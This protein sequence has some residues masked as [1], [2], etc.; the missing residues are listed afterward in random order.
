M[1]EVNEDASLL[2]ATSWQALGRAEIGRGDTRLCDSTVVI[3]FA[4]FFLE[5]SLTE[6][7]D[8]LGRMQDMRDFLRVQHPGLQDKLGW[9]YNEY[10]ARD[11]APT[12]K[13]MYK[14]GITRKLRRRFP[15]FS[16]I[17]KF[18]NDVAHGVINNSARSLTRTRLLRQQAKEIVDSLFEI[19]A[20]AGHDVLRETT[21]WQAITIHAQQQ[22]KDV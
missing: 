6:L 8:K 19:S 1:P 15:G 3:L 20:K 12:R 18:R 4:G 9:F 21:Y 22:S 10:V 17:H 14:R 7:I 2:I 11:K 16:T 13:Q 5:A